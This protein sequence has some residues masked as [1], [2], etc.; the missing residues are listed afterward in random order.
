MSMSKETKMASGQIDDVNAAATPPVHADSPSA[1]NVCTEDKQTE[2]PHITMVDGRLAPV[3]ED[4]DKGLWFHKL[5]KTLGIK[6]ASLAANLLEQAVKACFPRSPDTPEVVDSI[7]GAIAA[8]RPLDGVEAMLAAQAVVVHHH[9]MKLLTGAGTN[10]LSGVAENRIVLAEKLLKVFLLQTQRL[11]AHRNQSNQR[12]QVGEV[13]VH[14][15]GQ[16]I[17]GDVH[18]N[19]SENG[20]R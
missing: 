16:A 14:E 13:H 5:N 12:P 2:R 17:V 4:E 6:D 3:F 11:D 1:P 10:S 19:G 20:T 7:L 18:A 8:F 15:G 9:A